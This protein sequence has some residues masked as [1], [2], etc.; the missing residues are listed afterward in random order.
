MGDKWCWSGHSS[1]WEKESFCIYY[2][3]FKGIQIP[4]HFGF[5][6]LFVSDSVQTSK[7]GWMIDDIRVISPMFSGIGIKD[8]GSISQVSLYPN[9]TST[10]IFTVDYPFTSVK[11]TIVIYDLYGQK[12]KT[13]PLA[14]QIDVSDLPKG[15]Y[16]YSIVFESTKQRF[17][18]SFV[19][20]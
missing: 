2:L 7:P 16:L 19:Y 18:G 6:F 9:P 15:L 10:G 1:G 11:G 13:L 17:R 5:R 12:L 4:R 14:K 20:E 8:I 3:F